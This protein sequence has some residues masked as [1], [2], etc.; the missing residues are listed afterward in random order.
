VRSAETAQ[1][2]RHRQQF[3]GSRRRQIGLATSITSTHTACPSSPGE[4]HAFHQSMPDYSPTPLISVPELAT[5]LGIGRLLVK[6]ESSRLGLQAFKVLGVS[7]AC[8]SCA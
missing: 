8:R 1:A 6:D 3:R 5:E 7:W 2:G 4:A